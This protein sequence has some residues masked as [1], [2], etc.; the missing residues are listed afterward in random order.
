MTTQRPPRQFTALKPVASVTRTGHTPDDTA[1]IQGN[2][3]DIVSHLNRTFGSSGI[4]KVD[5]VKMPYQINKS[6]QDVQFPGSSIPEQGQSHILGDVIGRRF[7]LA[8]VGGKHIPFYR[9]SGY[10]GKFTSSGAST[11]GMWLPHLGIATDGSHWLNKLPGSGDYYGS[12]H[13][14]QIGQVLGQS[15]MGEGAVPIVGVGSPHAEFINSFMKHRPAGSP[16]R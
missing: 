16:D 9:S 5:L 13:L 14:A 2:L 15:S 8:K 4:D 6:A 1:R 10:G 7:A 11:G 12:H 3:D